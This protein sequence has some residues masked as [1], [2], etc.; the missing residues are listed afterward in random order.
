[1]DRAKEDADRSPSALT[2]DGVDQPASAAGVTEG[3]DSEGSTREQRGAGGEEGEPRVS[4]P[5]ETATHPPGE[6]THETAGRGRG[7]K[8]KAI[9]AHSAGE[10]EAQRSPE[11]R[12]KAEPDTSA[13]QDSATDDKPGGGSDIDGKRQDMPEHAPPPVGVGLTEVHEESA[14]MPDTEQT[15]EAAASGSSIS[16][17]AARMEAVRTGARPKTSKPASTKAGARRQKKRTKEAAPRPAEPPSKPDDSDQEATRGRTRHRERRGRS[18]SKQESARRDAVASSGGGDKGE[19]GDGEGTVPVPQGGFASVARNVE[20]KVHAIWQKYEQDRDAFDQRPGVK[21]F[22][23]AVVDSVAPEADFGVPFVS[24]CEMIM[25]DLDAECRLEA[26][27]K[28]AENLKATA[29]RVRTSSR[30]D[31]GSDAGASGG[32]D[33]AGRDVAVTDTTLAGVIKMTEMKVSSIRRRVI[34]LIRVL[35]TARFRLI[36]ENHLPETPRFLFPSNIAPSQAPTSAE[37]YSVEEI[38]LPSCASPVAALLLFVNRLT[39]WKNE[40]LAVGDDLEQKWWVEPEDPEEAVREHNRTVLAFE[41]ASATAVFAI[42]SERKKKWNLQELARVERNPQRKTAL[43]EASRILEKCID[44]ERQ[45]KLSRFSSYT[46]SLLDTATNRVKKKSGPWVTPSDSSHC[47]ELRAL[48]EKSEES[49]SDEAG[50]GG[51]E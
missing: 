36:L 6:K 5:S 3:L 42:L 37:G 25:T 10:G 38:H 7:K 44:E 43:E 21:T 26:L 39:A 28:V 31:E 33:G 47:P 46:E 50:A 45:Q 27:S 30:P 17:T 23:D 19:T 35:L 12:V 11:S 4:G 34:P 1:A 49:P 51:S 40:I 22:V 15:S 18:D 41:A 20:A 29:A 2:V 13:T 48:M 9:K 32:H 14:S 24:L 16:E 8:K